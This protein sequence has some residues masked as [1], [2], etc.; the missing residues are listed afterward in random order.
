MAR[1]CLEKFNVNHRV[2][3][4][5]AFILPAGLLFG[6]QYFAM[7]PYLETALSFPPVFILF[8]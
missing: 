2:K 1:D 5:C 3:K 6:S 8:F 7:L 4:F